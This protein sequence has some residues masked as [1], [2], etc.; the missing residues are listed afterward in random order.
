MAP[1]RE[2]SDGSP[3]RR[4]ASGD[5]GPAGVEI[6]RP[7]P[8]G[9]SIAHALFDHDGTISTLREGWERVME[10]MMVR[11]I[12]GPRPADAGEPLR[13]RIQR[14]VRELID[15]TTGHQTLVQMQA[16]A[17]MVREFGLVAP[18][19]V[20]DLHGYK[21]IYL[22]ELA[23][24]MGSR[25]ADLRSG[26]RPA[27]DFL[28]PGAVEFL[29][30][31]AGRGVKLYLASGTDVADV[32]DEA[33]LLG[34][35][36]LFDGRIYGAVGDVRVEAKQAVIESILREHDLPPDELAVVGD[37]P[38]EMRLAPPAA[39]RIG[40]ASD[41]IHPGRLNLAKRTRLIRAGADCIVADYAPAEALMRILLG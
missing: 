2:S 5:Q 7:R 28:I 24:M 19:D 25:L 34:Y 20:L 29:R 3:S 41:E 22:R 26:R 33:R 27:A 1:E 10:T 37:G 4:A 31:L 39:L 36:D 18:A 11:A 16:L 35:A 14:R 15:Q 12:L 40:V 30:L 38:V 6:I 13:D 32:R 8:P 17:E 23:A 9:P 21:A